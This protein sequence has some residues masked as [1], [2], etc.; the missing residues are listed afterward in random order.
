M[1]EG[2]DAGYGDGGGGGETFAGEEAEE[3][4]FASTVGW[5]S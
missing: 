4:R 2:V 5:D 3:S 1:L